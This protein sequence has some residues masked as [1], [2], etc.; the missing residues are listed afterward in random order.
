MD[1]LGIRGTKGFCVPDY[2][3]FADVI[4]EWA[5]KEKEGKKQSD[6]PALWWI[7]GAGNEVKWTFGD[8]AVNSKKVAN[9]LSNEADVKPGD[10]VMVILPAIPEYWLIQ[11]A[12]L[13]TGSVFLIMP[14]N[15]GPKELHRRMLKSKPVCVVAAP[16]D[17]VNNELLDVVDEVFCSAEVDI[18]SRILVN[19][20]KYEERRRDWLLF[21]D[22]FQKASADYHSVKSQSSD[23]V[24]IYHTSGTTGNSKMVEHSQASTGLCSGGMRRSHFVE[25]DL[26]WI[27][28]PT[29]WP[30]LSFVSF[31][32]TW[33]VGAGTFVHY[34]AFVTAR[35]ALETLQKHPITDAQFSHSLYL[36]ALDDEDLKSLSFAKLKRFF[37]AGEP[38]SKHMIR[39]WKE[40]T[41]IELWN[42]YGQTE[43]DILTFPR[44]PGD[45][46][47]PDSVGKLLTGIDMLIV[48]DKYNEV[49]PGTQGR[50]VIRVKP[51]CPVGMFTR[52]VDDPEKTESCFCGDFFITGDLG[53]MDEDGYFW[54]FGRTDD[55]LI[56][57]GCNII[58]GDVENCLKEHPAVLNCVVVS[59]SYLNRQIMKAFIVLSSGFKNENQDHLIKTLQDHVTYNS[60]SWMSPEKM[61]FIDDLPK[62]GTGKV[63]R[64]KLQCAD[65]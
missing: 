63:D 44:E 27:A 12:C 29:G 52:Y 33:S 38:A 49:T 36:K 43:T 4:D 3:N 22:L 19:R 48:D 41:G 55:V 65:L 31:F 34:V 15:V 37:V 9:L 2:F 47:R 7:D 58:P 61:E 8:V 39:R 35:E 26:I 46:S 30:V 10:R 51:Y 16:C 60:A 64:R 17:Q 5:Q 57:D 28:S 1:F 21:E 13:R 56:I 20:M 40:E 18:R 42:Y 59:V 50:V 11:A 25:S 24:I 32:S 54:I 62:T 14:T 23:P 45:D 6:H 53:R